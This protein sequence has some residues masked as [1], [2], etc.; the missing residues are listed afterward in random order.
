MVQMAADQP[1]KPIPEGLL[2]PM[3]K[4]EPEQQ[5]EAIVSG[6]RDICDGATKQVLLLSILAAAAEGVPLERWLE[7][8]CE[9]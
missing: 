9:I 6:I 5:K 4:L 8:A 7:M 3:A 2:R 1:A